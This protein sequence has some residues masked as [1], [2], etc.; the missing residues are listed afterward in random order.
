MGVMIDMVAAIVYR[1]GTGE[2]QRRRRAASVFALALALAPAA[3]LAAE[4][5]VF[6]AE[7]LELFRVEV[8]P[9]LEDNCFSCHGG[10]QR[11]R[12]SFRITTRAGLIRG[13]DRGPALNLAAPAKSLLLD[14]LS[15]RDDEHQMPPSGKL[16]EEEI[17]VLARWLELGAP[18]DPAAEIHPEK[19]ASEEEF[20]PT[21]VSERTKNY[22]AFRPLTRPEPPSSPARPGEHPI[23]AF[24]RSALE[25]A[26]LEPAARASRRELIRRAYHDLTGLPP[27][28]GEVRAFEEDDSP[29]AFERVVDRLLESPHYGERW[30][31]HWLDLVRF[32][33]SN[34]YERDSPKPMAHGYRNWVIQ[35]LNDD[36]P[37]DRF[38]VEQLAGDELEDA[39]ASKITATGFHR[40]GLWDD[41]PA[42]RVLARYDYLDDIA[43]TTAE[44]MLGL[45]IGCA[46]C[47]DHK[48]D[49]LPQRDYYRFLAF[50]ANISPHG[51]G[52]ANLVEVSS[53]EEER[54]AAEERAAKAA[55]EAELHTRI[56]EI[57]QAFVAAAR[58]RR[59]EILGDLTAPAD[60]V[61]LSYRFYRDTW[62]SLPEFDRLRPE[63]QGPLPDGRIT[64]APALSRDAMGLVFEGQ[65][66]VPETGEY[67]FRVM[68]HDGSRLLVAGRLAGERLG[69]GEGG[70]EGS[71]PLTAGYVPLRL[72]FF[73]RASEP[74]LEVAWSG[75]GFGWRPLSSAGD[76]RRILLSDARH[77][78]PVEWQ[79]TFRDPG[80]RWLEPGFEARRWRR[81]AGGFGAP[82]TPGAIVRTEWKTREIWLRR[83]FDVRGEVKRLALSLHHDEDARVYINGRLVHAQEGV[84]TD[85]TLVAIQDA[86]ELL[87]EGE[88]IISVHCR[89][90]Q[91]GQYIDAGLIDEGEGVSLSE[92]IA[93]Q[94][95]ELLGAE[96]RDA[97]FELALELAR[98]R[99]AP[100]RASKRKVL[101]VAEEGRHE[102]HVLLRGN[103]S[104]PG[105]RVEPGFPEVL[106]P[107]APE[108]VERGGTSGRRLAL[109]RWI[110][111]PE[112][113][114]TARVAANRIWQ[115][116][117]GRGIVRSS[118]NFGRLGDRPTHPELLDWLAAELQ[119]LEWR[120]KPFHRTILLSR[121]YQQT[122]RPRPEALEKDPQNDLFSRFD[123]RRLSAEEIRDSML[124]AARR[125]NRELYGRS[126]YS[127]LPPEVLATSSTGAE[128]W[129]RSPAEE[130]WRRSVY[131][132]V[133]RSLLDP[134]LTVFDFADT[135]ASCAVR[136]ATTV[137]TQALTMLNS[138]FVNE[139]AEALAERVAAS[140][141]APRERIRGGIELALARAA[142][143][144]EIDAG[145][146][147]LRE[148]EGEL[149]LDAN[150]AL[151]R[152]ALLLL[153]SNEFVYID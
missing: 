87:H 104:L 125:L 50:F 88:N 33:E 99:K 24:I 133:R 107:P 108:I 71:L 135:D 111:S 90:T 119:R 123:L 139:Q 32:A 69:S 98:S 70:F 65:L 97:Y 110:T 14:M 37:Y 30:G 36:M 40:L 146:E 94:G 80:E 53:P 31:R 52:E 152:F 8:L 96:R 49:P 20:D 15:Y 67:G 1:L 122:S 117:F 29:D 142:T 127:E 132:F 112:N 114:L 85:Y 44:V 54:L 38:L 43:S 118:S 57:E 145:V 93:R 128:K 48:I 27:S 68:S 39:N 46:R 56:W 4:E 28:F 59:P 106:S 13:G 58:E 100:P 129:G 105:E 101:A 18:F 55:R 151:A 19:E 148:F 17:A 75:P 61:E 10:R 6:G 82:G 95:A 11:I 60:L 16:A 22:W 2:R 147:M 9:I 89:Q 64:L 25:K 83:R 141:S 153:N 62:D 150:A 113:P 121:T 126:F 134:M 143:A 81:G 3:P 78:E 92:L 115:Y 103:P 35:A 63:T 116:H 140:W 23:D 131:I 5:R 124:A 86:A 149:G 34:G 42:D 74:R 21:A 73:S 84:R 7:A 144:A 109:A 77:G 91:G 102:M 45:T 136:F 138:K 41:E 26:G 51:A 130:T 66:R 72:E 137:P 47:H 12:G 120:L 76:C 79:Y